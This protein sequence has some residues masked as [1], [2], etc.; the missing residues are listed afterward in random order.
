MIN[1]EFKSTASDKMGDRIY[2]DYLSGFNS[3]E[4]FYF[5]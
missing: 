4:M 5:L 3:T 2:K 1:I